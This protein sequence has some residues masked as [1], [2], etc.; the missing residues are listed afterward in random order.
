[1]VS[2]LRTSTGMLTLLLTLYLWL[3]IHSFRTLHGEIDVSTKSGP[4]IALELTTNQKNKPI[5][6]AVPVH[7]NDASKPATFHFDK[8]RAETYLAANGASSLRKTLSAFIEPPLND[9]IPNTGSRGNLKDDKDQGTPPEFPIPMP[10]RTTTPDDLL[11]YEYPRVQTCHDLPG[12]WPV[13]KGL[14]IDENGNVVVWNVGDEP[15]PGDFPQQEAPYCPVELDPFLPWIH[16]VFPSIDGKRIEFIAQN[17]RRCRTGKRFTENVN[18]LVPQVALMQPVSVE[19]IDESKARRLAPELWSPKDDRSVLPRY[20]LA[21]FN[22]SSPDGMFTRYICRFHATDI[23]SGVPRTIVLDETLSEFPFN[24]EYVSYRKGKLNLLTPKGKDTTYFWSSVMRFNC[25]VPK[26]DHLP[27]SIASGDHVLSDG[28]PMIYVDLVPIRTSARYTEVH[29]TEELIGPREQW[30]IPAFDPVTRWGPKNVIPRV[31]A[32][33]R[34]TNIPICLPSTPPGEVALPKGLPAMATDKKPYFLAACLWASS[35][36]KTRGQRSGPVLDTLARIEE[37]IE[38]HLMVGIDH[39]YLYDNSGAH[40]NETSLA[41]LV[42]KFPGKITRFDWPAIPCNNNV[43][44]HDSTG[45]RSSQYASENSCRTRIAP[46]TEWIAVFDTDEYLVPMGDYTSLKDV[47][48]DRAKRGVKVLSLRSSRGKLRAEMCEPDRDGLQK[49]PNVTFLSAYN[50]DSGGIPKPG[51]ADRARKQIYHSDYVHY[52]YVHYSTVTSSLLK[53][54]SNESYWERIHKESPTEQRIPNELTEAVMVHTKTVT[55]PQTTAW[56]QECHKDF[57]KKWKGCYMAVPWPD[58]VVRKGNQSYNEE[59][60]LYNCF[61]NQKVDNY[62]APRLSEAMERRR[63]SWS[64][65]AFE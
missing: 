51:W 26:L 28:T 1:M 48:R 35:E 19:R 56:Q 53:P 27:E 16:D 11:R 15:T 33:G 20:R 54:Y 38:F 21:P 62:W 31:E 41:E 29:L 8:E 59:G 7:G 23:A 24:Y 39:F 18:R 63:Q 3:S 52:H 40:S 12:K 25:P 13:D 65:Q 49:R 50:C 46:F 57:D 30:Q 10:L 32:S 45:E 5:S 44:A 55:F 2:L 36:F 47:I 42:D 22:E 43:P 61:V 17:K 58:N 6:T 37:W 9:T 64:S 4:L 14:E 60:V 34:W